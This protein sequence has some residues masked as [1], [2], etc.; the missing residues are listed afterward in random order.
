MNRVTAMQVAMVLI[1]VAFVIAVSVPLIIHNNHMHNLQGKNVEI[2]VQNTP[3]QAPFTTPDTGYTQAINDAESRINTKINSLEQS[4]NQM[5][6]SAP[7]KY[8]C[9][10]EGIVDD[11]G[12]VTPA[13][14]NIPPSQSVVLVCQS[15]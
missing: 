10:L 15:K 2:P 4:I 1:I 7:G 3:V 12:N 9:S 14:G 6:S 11:H 8:V 5:K 13:K